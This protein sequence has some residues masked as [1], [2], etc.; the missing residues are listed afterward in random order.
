MTHRVHITP[1]AIEDLA[2]IAKELEAQTEIAGPLWYG[3]L[4]DQILALCDFPMRCPIA[5]DET[6]RYGVEVRCLLFGRRQHQRRILYYIEGTTVHVLHVLH[7]ARD[8]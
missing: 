6:A 1:T 5:P 4:L 8:R 3:R 7:G 2:Q